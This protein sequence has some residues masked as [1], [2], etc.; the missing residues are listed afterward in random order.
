[1][2]YADSTGEAFAQR[3][4]IP[5]NYGT[6]SNDP[7]DVT[8]NNLFN[9]TKDARV[10]PTTAPN[11]VGDRKLSAQEI[12][13]YQRD[14]GSRSKQLVEAFIK[15]DLYKSLTNEERADVL[16]E[17]YGASKAITERDMFGKALSDSSNYAKAVAAFDTDKESGVLNHLASKYNQYGLDPEVYQEMV[18]NNEDFTPYEGYKDALSTYQIEDNAAYRTAYASGKTPEQKLA[19]LDNEVQYQ[20]ACKENGLDPDGKATRS[21]WDS[22]LHASADPNAAL[23]KV[24]ANRETAMN[25]GFVTSDGKVNQAA[26]DKAVTVLGDDPAVLSGYASFKDNATEKNATRIDQYIPMVEAIPGLTYEQKGQYAYLYGGEPTGKSAQKALANSY[27]AYYLYRLLQNAP[28]L[29]DNGKSGDTGDR[30][31]YLYNLGYGQDKKPDMY[32]FLTDPDM[33]Y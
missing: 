28:D 20:A 30:I 17:I 31:K 16:N 4:L 29:N 11:K 18:D 19:N 27:E 22:A 5:G 15:S 3:F 1:M 9:D 24:A 10:F 6:D 8:I 7:V 14:M 25:T 21:A 12:S 23:Q 2:N 13:N 32:S 33:S 26:Y